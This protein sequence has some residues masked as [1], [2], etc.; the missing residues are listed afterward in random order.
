MT[1]LPKQLKQPKQ[2]KQPR[3]RGRKPI[4]NGET[5][6]VDCHIGNRLRWRRTLL[7]LSQEKLGEKI[8]LSFQQMQKYE[9]GTNRI[10][11]SR[12]YELAL[13]MNVPMAFFFDGLEPTKE[14]PAPDVST[15]LYL[16]DPENNS[17]RPKAVRRD[18]LE[19]ARAFDRIEDESMR[20]RILDLTRAVAD[21]YVGKNEE[22]LSTVLDINVKENSF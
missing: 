1:Q 13:I 21:L 14:F 19:L 11:A 4:I 15:S 8:G 7:G 9:R 20:K 12:L 22:K 17:Y 3:K 5:N 10:D 2:P 18:L 6:L 16:D